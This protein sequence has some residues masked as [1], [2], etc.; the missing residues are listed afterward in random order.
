MAAVPRAE[1]EAAVMA[2]PL[3]APLPVEV[4]DVW[5]LMR[6]QPGTW[7]AVSFGGE[8]APGGAQHGIVKA[9]LRGKPGLGPAA[10][11]LGVCN[12]AAGVGNGGE[13]AGELF[14]VDAVLLHQLEFIASASGGHSS[15][16][17]VRPPQFAVA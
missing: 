14:L 11:A 9:A 3:A 1:A 17:H 15:L 13:A 10:R 6:D 8:L 16:C 12:T 7:H 2:A 5:R 4:E